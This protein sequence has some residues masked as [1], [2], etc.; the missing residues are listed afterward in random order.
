MS[1]NA[2]G[3]A[4]RPFEEGDFRPLVNILAQTWLA[5]YP[6]L[7]G[8]LASTVELC[9]YLSQATW[10]RVA[11]RGGRLLG[12]VLLREPDR[13]PEDADRWRERGAAAERE[14]AKAP[15][16]A[17]VMDLEMAGVIEEAGLERDYE[18]TGTAE[19]S[20]AVKLL[21]V[22]PEARGLGV[23]GRLFCAARSYLRE[24]GA[25][26]YHLLTDDSCDI[27]FYDHMGLRQEM[28][29]VSQVA[30]PGSDPA[31]DSFHIYVYSERL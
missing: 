24:R 4:L 12:A 1:E 22:S 14:A 10:S 8:E 16:C 6:G 20:F 3:L 23:G 15:E 30:W 17:R 31:G 13:V 5:D 19:A 27:S 29:R 9:D 18:M 7:P 26:G 21:I 11:E 28:S 2:A 25:A